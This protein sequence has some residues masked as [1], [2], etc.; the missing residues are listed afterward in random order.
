MAF[1]TL[2]FGDV[3]L[4]IELEQEENEPFIADSD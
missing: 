1:I 2:P 4:K 3:N